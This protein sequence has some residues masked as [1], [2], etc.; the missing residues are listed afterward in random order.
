MIVA[1]DL[2]DTLYDE[3]TFV[4]S[5][6]RAV[7]SHLEQTRG[8]PAAESFAVLCSS[9]DSAPR[10]RQIDDL[11]AHWGLQGKRLVSALVHVY[12]HH[13]PSLALPEESRAALDALRQ[14]GHR[15][16]LVTDGHKVV[17]ANKVAALGVARYFE[18]CYLTNRYGTAHNK[19]SPRVFELMLRREGAEPSQ[20]VYVGDDPAKDFVGVRRLGGRTIRVRTGRHSAVAARDAG[21]EADLEVASFAQVPAAVERLADSA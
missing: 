10:G 14:A 7:A 12:R 17:Q 16:Y 18:H 5:G 3:R 21:H 9:L 19:P 13:P 2:D 11:L 15:L 8:L 1:V 4:E 6:F 20:L